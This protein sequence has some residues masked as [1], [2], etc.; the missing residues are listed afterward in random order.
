MVMAKAII[1]IETIS[2][3]E[4]PFHADVRMKRTWN[5]KFFLLN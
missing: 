4:L 1:K 2:E 3:S 5:A